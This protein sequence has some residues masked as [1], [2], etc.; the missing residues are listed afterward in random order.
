MTTLETILAVCAVVVSISFSSYFLMVGIAA[1]KLA[2]SG[3]AYVST[4]ITTPKEQP[5]Q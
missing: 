1:L 3:I 5:I 2:N 4:N